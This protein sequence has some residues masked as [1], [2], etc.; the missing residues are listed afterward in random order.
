[1]HHLYR[2]RMRRI[3]IPLFKVEIFSNLSPNPHNK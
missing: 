1:M 3:W 2:P